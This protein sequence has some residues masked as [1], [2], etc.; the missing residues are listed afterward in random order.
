M[1]PSSRRCAPKDKKWPQLSQQ[2]FTDCFSLNQKFGMF[3]KDSSSSVF[4][5]VPAIR[6]RPP[7]PSAPEA[8]PPSS[9]MTVHAKSVGRWHVGRWPELKKRQHLRIQDSQSSPPRPF[10]QSTPVFDLNGSS[11][12]CTSK[13]GGL[14]SRRRGNRRCSY[15]LK[16]KVQTCS[17]RKPNRHA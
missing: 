6:V 5:H 15:M 8:R 10:G 2:R 1:R 7:P 4:S 3:G 13:S 17:E 9:D 16:H 11:V 12:L 14:R